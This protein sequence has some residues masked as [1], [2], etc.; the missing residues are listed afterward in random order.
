MVCYEYID[1]ILHRSGKT[2]LAINCTDGVLIC[3]VF[4]RAD[5]NTASRVSVKI[6]AKVD[7]E[8]LILEVVLPDHRQYLLDVALPTC[9][10]RDGPCLLVLTTRC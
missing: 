10:D 4:S 7:P 9:D 1:D 6:I 5:P 8:A 3:A 2:V